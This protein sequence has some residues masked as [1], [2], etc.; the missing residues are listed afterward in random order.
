ME[1]IENKIEK[2]NNKKNVQKKVLMVAGLALLLGFVGYTGGTTYAKYVTSHDTESQ[3]ATV[4]QWGY[5][6]S[7]NTTE[8]FGKE[9]MDDS[10]AD[11]NVS[12]IKGTTGAGSTL[13]ISGATNLVAP[14]AK[15]QFSFNVSGTA[16]V[17]SKVE[18]T[19]TGTPIQLTKFCGTTLDTPYEPIKWSVDGTAVGTGIADTTI[20]DWTNLSFSELKDKINSLDDATTKLAPNTDVNVNL[21]ISWSWAFDGSSVVTNGLT[22]NKLDTALGDVVAG[23]GNYFENSTATTQ[24]N[25]NLLLNVEQLAE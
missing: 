11:S 3:K 24:M 8:L 22:G 19:L 23:K 17:L 12:L 20:D 4:A 21:V 7:A 13:T 25:L 2:R 14:G 9:Y 6:V 18:I 10:V 5:T 1:R 16:E 15:G